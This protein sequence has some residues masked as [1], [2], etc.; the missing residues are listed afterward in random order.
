MA[1]SVQEA[2]SKE[3]ELPID[4]V[5]PDA[6]QPAKEPSADAIGF[7]TVEHAHPHEYDQIKRSR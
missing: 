4:G 2:I 3:P 6:V 7:K 5:F 1:T